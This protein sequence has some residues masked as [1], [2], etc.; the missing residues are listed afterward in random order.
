MQP[1]LWAFF[2]HL[3]ILEYPDCHQILISSSL[4]YPGPLHKISPGVQFPFP[5]TSEVL[6]KLLIPLLQA[7]CD[8]K[9]GQIY[10]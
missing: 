9:H 6:D 5:D 1:L 10:N 2:A 7:T 4:Y 3:L 8:I